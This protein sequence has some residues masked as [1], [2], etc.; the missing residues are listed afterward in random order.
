MA[1]QRVFVYGTLR[2]GL[3]FSDAL[4]DSE[5][6]GKGETKDE[7]GFFF[8]RYPAATIFSNDVYIKGEVYVIA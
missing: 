3:I 4:E 8:Y 2:K 1:K 6:I 7:F 5:Y